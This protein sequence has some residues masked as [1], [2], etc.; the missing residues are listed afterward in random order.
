M[1]VLMVVLGVWD[2]LPCVCFFM[3]IFFTSV[4]CWSFVFCSFKLILFFIFLCLFS[5]LFF[6]SFF[7]PF[8]I[9]FFKLI[10]Y[11][12]FHID[13]FFKLSFM[14]FTVEVVVSVC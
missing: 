6:S 2:P 7:S 8:L 4:F 13:F 1:G 5:L 10:F 12:A 3:F 11:I 14:F 9:D